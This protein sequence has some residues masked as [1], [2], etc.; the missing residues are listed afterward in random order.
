MNSKR[1]SLKPIPISMRLRDIGLI[2]DE[3]Y[4]KVLVPAKPLKT[5][6]NVTIL[7]FDT[8]FDPS[9]HQLLSVQLACIV[10]NEVKSRVYYRD[11]LTPE[12]L[13]KLVHNFLGEIGVH[14]STR[15][16]LVAHFA[17]SDIAMVQNHL[18]EFRLRTYNKAMS[19]E[20]EFTWLE[21]ET[22]DEVRGRVAQLGKYR[23][24]IID[25]YGYLPTSLKKI[26]EMVGLP[27]LDL[28]ASRITE[29]MREDPKHFEAYAKRDAEITIKAFIEMRK[30]FLDEYDVHIAAT[31]T[32]KG[33]ISV[34]IVGRKGKTF[35]PEI[36]K[37]K[38][39]LIKFEG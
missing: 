39:F 32:M 16:V 24:K 13:L 15:I 22:E 4:L 11:T 9:S 3:K 1:D 35:F 26:G 37:T 18:R 38:S 28:D 5:M 25:L 33:L 19:A 2:S 27:K 14:P 20:G 7:G 34:L 10:G 30:K 31:F 6:K 12:D 36:A 17:Q 21:E 29:I 8:E 23:L